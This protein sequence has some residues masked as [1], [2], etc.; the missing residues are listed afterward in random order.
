M[1]LK[2]LRPRAQ[3]E[4]LFRQNRM[5]GTK[6]NRFDNSGHV[7]AAAFSFMKSA[8]ASLQAIHNTANVNTERLTRG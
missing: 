1:L 6:P 5:I 2:H 4:L 3:T 8:N 7:A